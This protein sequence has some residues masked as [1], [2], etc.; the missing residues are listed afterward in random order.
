MKAHQL[1]AEA[2]SDTLDLLSTVDSHEN[3]LS[4][5]WMGALRDHAL[6]S[7]P[8]SFATQL[9]P[10]SGMFYCADTIESSKIHYRRMWP[11][12]LHA[13]AMWLNKYPF[14]SEM[15]KVTDVANEDRLFLSIG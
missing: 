13:A 11:S 9:S 14:R 5:L 6:L 4:E 15:D 12:I 8:A 1:A 3:Y 2:E 7:L 10:N